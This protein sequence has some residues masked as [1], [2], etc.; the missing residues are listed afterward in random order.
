V[1]VRGRDAGTPYRLREAS[2]G[3]REFLWRLHR[4]TMKDYVAAT[5]GW[6]ERFQREFFDERFEPK[7]LRIV[8]VG[9]EDAGMIATARRAEAVELVSIRVAPAF[10][11]RGIG[12]GLVE[13]VLAQA[14]EEG[15]RVELSVLKA[16]PR[17]KE[18]YERLGF[19]VS[20]ETDTHH[21]M[22]SSA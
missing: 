22:S 11:G 4:A 1:P 12:A 21:R 13:D 5:W 8:V 15:L 10:Q 20:G 19:E 17:A 3:D 9:G 2:E 16:N 6:D 18:L 7:G 14:R